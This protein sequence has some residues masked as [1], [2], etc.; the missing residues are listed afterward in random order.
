MIALSL[1]LVAGFA[2]AAVPDVWF[3][4][5]GTGAPGPAE[6]AE[7]FDQW[8]L[9]ERAVYVI[10]CFGWQTQTRHIAAELDLAKPTARFYLHAA[11]RAGLAAR[12]PGDRWRLTT[13]ARRLWG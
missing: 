4:M 7:P 11:E 3:V 9:L 8:P 1:A 2:L 6:R 5:R 10:G 12:L 13:Q